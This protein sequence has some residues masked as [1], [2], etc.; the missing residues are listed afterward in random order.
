MSYISP[1]GEQSTVAEIKELEALNN[2][3]VG[4]VGTAIQK[5]GPA[6]FANIVIAGVGTVSSVAVATNN[7]F[8]GTSDGNPGSPTLTLTT[9]VTGILKGNGS[10]MSA[11]TPGVDYLTSATAVP[12]TGATANLDL[13][14]HSLTGTNFINSGY[15]D[16]A[17][18]ATP[19]SPAAGT[20][21]LYG[22]AQAGSNTG[23]AQIDDDGVIRI[24]GRDNTKIVKNV[25][26]VLI[27]KGSAVYINGATGGTPTVALAK[28]NSVTTLPALGVTMTDI[29]HN[30]FGYVMILGDLIGVV[31]TSGFS[32]GDRVYVSSTTAGAITNVRPVYPNLQQRLATVLS[33][34]NPGDLEM[35][36][37][38]FIGGQELGSITNTFA[39]GDGGAGTKTI[40]FNNASVGTLQWNPTLARTL[41]LPDNTG[42]LLSSASQGNLTAGSSKIS[43]GGTGTGA[44]I[45]AGAS[46]DLGTVNTTDLAD[47][48]IV[49]PTTG[50]ILTWNGSAW[51]NSSGVSAGAGPGTTFFLDSAVIIPAGSGPQTQQELTLLK[52]PSATGE[53]TFAVSATAATSP[54]FLA[55]FLYNTAL[56]GTQI[57]GGAWVFNNYRT[58]SAAAGT[59]TMVVAAYRVI[60]G[61]GTVTITGAGTSRTATVTGG[62]PFVSGDA[63][64]DITLA[65]KLQTPNGIF[66][67]SAFVNSAVVTVVTLST[68][69]DETSVAYSTHRWLF[70]VT[71]ADINDTSVAL[72]KITTTQPAFSINS[73]DKFAVRYFATSTNAGGHTLTLYTNGTSH[74]SNVSTP[75]AVRHNDLLG[76]QG[77]T[78]SG[79]SGEYYHLTS[80]EYTGT[81]TGNF[82]RAG[83]PTITTPTVAS[84]ANANHNHQ[85]SAGG[86]TLDVAAI[87]SGI[88]GSARG[89]TG[90]GFTKFTGPTTSEKTFTLPDATS[91]IAVTSMN[92]SSFAATTSAQLAGVISD[93]TGSNKLVFSDT[94]TLVTPVLGVATFTSLNKVGWTA[95]TTAGTLAFPTDNATITFQGTDTYIGRATTDTLTNKFITPQLQ[96]VADAGGTLTPV[97]ITNDLVIATAL[98]QATT[99]AA[100]TGSPVQG[101]NLIIRL[102]D[103]GT[104]RA[105]TWNSIYRAG[106]DVAL[107]TTT[108]LSK[109]LYCGFK[110]NT[111]DTKWDLLAVINNI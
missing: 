85:N 99:I 37:A 34:G 27:A 69:T 71:S 78:G 7:G 59:D 9:T 39:L 75:L 11:A 107:P 98:S 58:T 32:I 1:Q 15:L 41:T 38:P 50:Q 95:P 70:N 55:G 12:Y 87:A 76:L 61:A 83:S 88:L 64:V 6:S 29:A 73:T 45:G 33:S 90:N 91:T 54:V 35:T 20:L 24:I 72:E 26:G 92:L 23:F 110:Y 66:S 86:E 93:E 105:L 18:I 111:T 104:A 16:L 77:G 81:G 103:N 47:T 48:S 46:V 57:D 109:T 56:G 49:S 79:N 36:T 60:T 101:E 53:Q 5:T 2:L 74:A 65:G 94:P 51:A 68:Y 8:A 21:R 100:P 108:V 4:G 25:T 17:T 102:K 62:T 106:S 14:V 42:T 30:A 40:T 10:S 96:S 67:I 97:S 82:V 13:G 84:F 31:D 89:G 3:A 28:A 63:N 19:A 52:S 43:I 22:I 80:A 44:V